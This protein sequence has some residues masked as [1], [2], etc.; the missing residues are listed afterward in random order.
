MGPPGSPL[1]ADSN[2]TFGNLSSIASYRS[3]DSAQIDLNREA[4][5]DEVEVTGPEAFARPAASDTTV[6]S[7]GSLGAST[8]RG[9]LQ[10]DAHSNAWD[11]NQATAMPYGGSYGYGYDAY[12]ATSSHW[13]LQ[14]SPAHEQG[15][16][17]SHLP[18]GPLAGVTR[19]SLLA[20]V[21]A[22]MGYASAHGLNC[23]LDSLLQLVHGSRRWLNY[24][25]PGLAQ[26]V[27]ALRRNLVMH[28]AAAPRGHIDAEGANVLAVTLA[29]NY[30]VRIQFIE[31]N[32]DRS[33]IVHPVYGNQ[34]PFLHILHTPGHF[35]PLW[36]K[37]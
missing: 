7:I 37:H 22:E 17:L 34:G 29:A 19:A 32:E 2:T 33:L 25:P 27:A 18:V 14:A 31:E 11:L 13:T 23:L 20:Q 3:R 8:L 35:Q 36:P 10:D 24:E 28:G 6:R 9:D 5:A 1:P 4:D 26:E 15:L 16:A 30:G 21:D 12:A